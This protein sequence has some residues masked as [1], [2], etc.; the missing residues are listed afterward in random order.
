MTI[1]RLPAIIVNDSTLR[2]GENAPHI[3][4]TRQ[5]RIDIARSLEQAGVDEIE[6]GVPS[7]HNAAI[8]EMA[9]VG[10][11]LTHAKP[12]AWGGMARATVDATV[13]AGIRAVHLCVPLGKPRGGRS[14]LLDRIARVVGYATECGL[15]VAVSGEDASRTDFDFVCDAMAA[16]EAAGAHRFRYADT[17][18]VLDPLKTHSLFRQLCAETDLELEFHGHDDFGLATANTLAAVQGGATHVS[19]SVLGLGERAGTAPLEAVVSA[20]RLSPLHHTR[21]DPARLPALACMVA[22]AARL[23]ANTA[24]LDDPDP[25]SKPW[26]GAMARILA[27]MPLTAASAAAK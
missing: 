18:G 24:K 27:A 14:S 13:R 8:D 23:L 26:L 20:I 15:N 6:I 17:M 16:A 10:M 11:V 7:G 1:H 25:T 5:N 19:V 4:F 12:V 9:A 21:V 3:T 22:S 2:D